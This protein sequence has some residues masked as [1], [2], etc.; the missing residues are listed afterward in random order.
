M[1]RHARDHE[2]WRRTE[3]RYGPV[4]AHEIMVAADAARRH[5]HRAGFN[6]EVAD[7]IAGRPLAALHGRRCKHLARDA[8]RAAVRHDDAAHPMPAF[9]RDPTRLDMGADAPLERLDDA[10]PG[11]P[12]EMESRHRIAVTIRQRAAA[13]GPADD[14]KPPHALRMQP[15]PHLAGREVDV[16]LGA[17]ARPEIFRAIELRRAKPVLQG[18]VPAVTDAEPPLL[19][20]V[21]EEQ[22]AE[23]P[24]GLAAERILALLFDDRDAPAG[25]GQFGGRHE[26]GEPAAHHNGIRAFRHATSRFYGNSSSFRSST[27]SRELRVCAVGETKGP[28]TP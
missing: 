15:W 24:E 18:E 19:G 13:L 1:M 6:L 10:R 22:A 20:T 23:R 8:G 17:S 28:R 21:Y 25:V 5:E 14:R 4:R 16:G 27:R 12:G 2:V 3:A 26:T 7:H 11:T 9:Q